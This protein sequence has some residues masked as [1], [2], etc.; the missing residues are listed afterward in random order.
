MPEHYDN[1]FGER[2]ELSLEDVLEDLETGLKSMSEAHEGYE[3]AE[4]YAEGRAEERFV[5]DRVR[6]LL[7]GSEYDFQVNLTGRVIK[8]VTDRLEIAA[9]TAIDNNT[10]DVPDDEP[11]F[12]PD[13]EL[14][15]ASAETTPEFSDEETRARQLA[16]KI[17]LSYNEDLT[18][19]LNEEV[20]HRNELDIEAPEIHSKA[21]M[22]GDSYL[23]VWPSQD[24]EGVDVFY[25]SPESTRIFYDPENPR[26]KQF[27]IKRWRAGRNK[28]RVNLYY[29]DFIVKLVSKASKKGTKATEFEPH[30]DETTDGQG[31]MENPYGEIPIFHF[32]TARPYGKPEHMDA[33]GPQDAITK[34]STGL[35][36]VTDFA[37]YPQRFIISRLGK[38]DED[39]DIDWGDDETQDPEDKQSSLISGPGRVW[40]L[41]NADKAGEF[42]AANVDQ[43]LKPM[44]KYIEL[45]ASATGTPLSHL[46]MVRGTTSTPLSG[47]SQEK[48]ET[49]L[50][51]KIRAR[52]RSYGATW[53][54]ALQFAMKILGYEDVSVSVQWASLVE[55]GT[56]DD[57]DGAISQQKAGVPIRQVLLEMGYT[58]TLVDSWGYTAED[59]N[60]FKTKAVTNPHNP[61]YGQS[62]A[63]SG[64]IET[65][66]PAVSDELK[67]NESDLKTESEE[68]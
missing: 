55:R 35:M 30:L 33:Y 32:R 44:D 11:D 14:G 60:G 9:V 62:V 18:D 66:Q 1:E 43:F 45:M 61:F 58:E 13:N 46:S 64:V 65:P 53:R 5:T 21:G 23:F 52:Q 31:F 41:D 38:G 63:E 36:T 54:E 68:D 6:K 39:D 26:V 4:D 12:E 3:E 15:G 57:W 47:P 19:I 50:V 37:A 40:K 28:T 16:E 48:A 10:P 49:V 22:F 2:E 42:Q 8:A 7:T 51:K 56:K 24:D 27:A 59:P 17:S 29:P 67:K 34:L 20:W 25:N